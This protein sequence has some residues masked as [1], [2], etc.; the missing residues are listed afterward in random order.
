MCVSEAG[1]HRTL[2]SSPSWIFKFLVPFRRL[3][4]S[5]PD[6]CSPSTK[7][8]D[9]NYDAQDDNKDGNEG[10]EDPGRRRHPDE[11]WSEV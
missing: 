10:L 11:H 3:L 2:T 6:V 7:A 8:L 9:E 1:L 5:I 4:V